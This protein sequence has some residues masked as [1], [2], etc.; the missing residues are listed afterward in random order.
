MK[1]NADRLLQLVNDFLDFARLDAKAETLRPRAT[2]LVAF[3]RA[4]ARPFESGFAQRAI[5]F[6]ADLPGEPVCASVDRRKLEKVVTNL[7]GN[8]IKFTAKGQVCL[9]LRRDLGSIR[10]EV[11]DT[12]PGIAE[13]DLPKLFQRFRQVGSTDSKRK[14]GSGIGLALARSLAELHG[15]KITC[16]SKVGQGSTFTVILP[17][18]PA[19]PPERLETDD[20]APP[21]ALPPVE[22]G[23]GGDDAARS[24]SR[25]GGPPRLRVLLVEDDPDLGSFLEFLLRDACD[26]T[27]LEDGHQA[28]A[29]LRRKG[30]D[31]VITDAMLPRM[32]GLDL[33][34]AVKRD[35]ALRH[36]PVILSTALSSADATAAF[37]A[38]I[39]DFVLKPF[40]PDVI[41]AKIAVLAQ[42]KALRDEVVKAA[43]IAALGHL[44]TSIEREVCADLKAAREITPRVRALGNAAR[45]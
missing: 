41:L 15:G 19:G 33:C 11:Q 25:A 31:V 27:V 29:H 7:L 4:I 43:R 30:A 28:L 21:L 42:V 39:D 14:I 40:E 37:E 10:I 32:S 5:G 26:A 13:A 16:K 2:D 3:L 6:T 34:R 24:D 8:A 22:H 20:D 36:I 12:G 9:R 1:R 17:D 45:E 23:L 44:G 35:P 38:G 18:V